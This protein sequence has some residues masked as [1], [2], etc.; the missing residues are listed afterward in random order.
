VQATFLSTSTDW[1]FWQCLKFPENIFGFAKPVT[2]VVTD[3]NEVRA[4]HMSRWALAPV[5]FVSRKAL[6]PG[7]SGLSSHF[8]VSSLQSPVS[9]LQS[10]VSSPE[11]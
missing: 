5:Y 8:P 7:F 9:S 4:K 2:S 1:S 11:A 6:G 3:R 10:P